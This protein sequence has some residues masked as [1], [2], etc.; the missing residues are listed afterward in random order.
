[1]S[2]GETDNCQDSVAWHNDNEKALGPDP[3]IA[4]L[5]L[6]IERKCELKHP[7]GNAQKISL[8][9]ADSSLLLMGR[10]WQ[11]Q[12]IH[13]IPKQTWITQPRIDLTFRCIH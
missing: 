1:M 4:S 7:D 12:W 10:G 6:A 2:A 13:Q 3:F 8:E 9:L 5:S 11:Q